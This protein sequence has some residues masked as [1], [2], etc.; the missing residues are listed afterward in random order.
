[1]T[2]LDP[3]QPKH[4]AAE[5][6]LQAEKIIWLTTVASSGQPQSTPVWF[7]WEAGEFLIY[8]ARNSPKMASITASPRVGLHLEGNGRGGDNVI[9]EATARFDPD[10]PA[11]DTVPA[12]L[13][14]YQE[15]IDAYNWTAASFARDYPHVIR[16]TPTRARIW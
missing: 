4:V 12:Y 13:S 2:I 11:A 5:Q 10:G 9:F 6:R 16:A 3:G 8:G 14:R 7:L 1:M 15:F